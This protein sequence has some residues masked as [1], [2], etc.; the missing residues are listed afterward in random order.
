MRLFRQV[1]LLAIA[2]I[3]GL[4][5]AANAQISPLP[6]IDQELRANFPEVGG[7]TA[8]E[9]Q[10]LLNGEEQPII[11]DVR[12]AEEFAVS[13]LQGAVRIDPDAGLDDVL[14]AIGPDL[15]GR[16]IIVY[17]SVGVRSTQLAARVYEGLKSRGA[18]RVANL[19]EG[20][21][22]WH[23]AKRPLTRGAQATSYVH[24]YDALWGL[25]LRQQDLTAY[26]PVLQETKPTAGPGSDQ[27]T[28]YILAFL[29]GFALL[30]L[31]LSMRS[32]RFRQRLG[33]Q[34]S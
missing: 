21:F 23:N 25:L 32:R 34:K 28:P 12:E 9:L 19:S 8:A 16:A 26:A 27:S 11:L 17:C 10:T 2:I 7:I 1:L 31:A 33:D 5:H 30:V 4:S 14:Q 29:G 3:A 15:K 20:I 22:G 18:N 6:V 13:H 24:P